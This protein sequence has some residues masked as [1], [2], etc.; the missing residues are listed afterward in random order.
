MIVY[1]NVPIWQSPQRIKSMVYEIF[2][3]KQFLPKLYIFLDFGVLSTMYIKC[4]MNLQDHSNIISKGD[5][6]NKLL[7][8]GNIF[9][10]A[11][12]K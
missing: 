12:K 11:Q 9:F 3:G 2:W 7:Q 5:D 6:T 8:V 4:G 10:V 1:F